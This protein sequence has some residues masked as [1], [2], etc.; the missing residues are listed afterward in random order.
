[1][2]IPV[3]GLLTLVGIVLALFWWSYRTARKLWKRGDTKWG[4]LV[5]NYRVRGF[6]ASTAR[7]RSLLALRT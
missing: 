1:M 7:C 4:R 2:L 3:I 5:Y 6:G